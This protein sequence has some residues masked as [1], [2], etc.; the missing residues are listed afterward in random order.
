MGITGLLLQRDCW[1]PSHGR[2]VRQM[3]HAGARYLDA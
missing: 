1:P 3:A 2:S